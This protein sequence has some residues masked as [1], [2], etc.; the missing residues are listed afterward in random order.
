M[1]RITCASVPCGGGCNCHLKEV[2]PNNYTCIEP[3]ISIS[4]SYTF[5]CKHCTTISIIIPN[6]SICW[7]FSWLTLINHQYSI[8]FDFHLKFSILKK[9]LI[10]YLRVDCIQNV[11]HIFVVKST[12]LWF[13][14]VCLVV[15]DR[16]PPHY[17]LVV[18]ALWL[19]TEVHPTMVW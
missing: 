19:A 3:T 17:G 8:D 7:H 2:S 15:E 4:D 13:G 14:S 6:N 1:T 11:V 9:S 18:Y 16:G 12:R 5:G 10:C